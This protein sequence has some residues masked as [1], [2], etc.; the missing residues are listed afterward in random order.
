[1]NKTAI[2][3]GTGM[4]SKTLTHILLS[5]NYRVIITHRR[6]SILD[7]T[8]IK[9]YFQE[10]LFK[11]PESSLEFYLM[12]ITELKSVEET[13][14][15]V[16]K[17]YNKIDEFYHL[18][19]FTH[20]G[21]SFAHPLLS[22]NTNGCSAFFIL[23]TLRKYSSKTRFY[24][25]NTSECFGGDPNNCPFRENSPQ[26]LRSPYAWG[27]NLGANITKYYRQTYDMY[28]CFGWLFN[29]S[30]IYRHNSF[31]FMKVIRG[32]ARISLGK[33]NELALGFLDFYR[34]EHLSDF[35]CEIMWKMLNNP[36]GPIDYVIGNGR[37]NHG[38]EYLDAAFS[39]FN[40]NW[41][42]YVK[43]D[44]TLLR[45][46]E[47]IKLVSDPTKAVMDLGWEQ[48]RVSLKE[49]VDLVSKYIYSE[50]SGQKPVRENVFDKFP[51]KNYGIKQQSVRTN[52]V[53]EKEETVQ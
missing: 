5:K 51:I 33:Q 35:G 32:A 48:N 39:Y 12:D 36:K 19:G 38:E 25:A 14:L 41:K 27:K 21:D 16:L 29:H 6:N 3:S 9:S 22:V 44:K 37:A 46:N 10:E 40:L 31:Y 2:I 8:K 28:A 53:E 18:A 17:K 30:N 45:P 47:V 20:V 4:D 52:R 13:I 42:D 50:E 43:L 24:F 34:D 26:E 1:M 49:H 7:L 23:E 11:Y 15:E